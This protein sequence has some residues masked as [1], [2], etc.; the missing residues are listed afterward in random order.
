MLRS[1]CA[2]SASSVKPAWRGSNSRILELASMIGFERNISLH[3]YQHLEI[4]KSHTCG[5]KS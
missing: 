5:V 2:E 4:Q 3:Q 1:I